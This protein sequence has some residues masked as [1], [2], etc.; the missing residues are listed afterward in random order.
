MPAQGHRS[1]SDGN[2]RR[3]PLSILLDV[4]DCLHAV[5]RRCRA[6]RCIGPSC[7]RQC[8]PASSR[9]GPM[10][11]LTPAGDG[12]NCCCIMARLPKF[13]ELNGVEAARDTPAGTCLALFDE[14]RALD[15][16]LTAMFEDRGGIRVHPP[17]SMRAL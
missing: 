6:S 4:L 10:N 14:A 11:S 5:R 7:L 12:A 15:E 16:R 13:M 8:G 3:A 1:P 9:H 17:L 2:G